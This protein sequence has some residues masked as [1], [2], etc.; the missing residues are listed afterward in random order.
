M[1]MKLTVRDIAK[2]RPGDRPYNVEDL[3]TRGLVLRVEP[4]GIMT[5][6]VRYR[7]QG[8]QS[9]KKLGRVDTMPPEEARRRAAKVRGQA[10]DGIDPIAAERAAKSSTLGAF[11]ENEYGPRVLTFKKSGVATQAR[12]KDCFDFLWSRPL[13]DPTL[14]GAVS[15]WRSKRLKEGKKPATVNRDISALKHILSWAVAEKFL[16]THPLAEVK[17]IKLDKARIVRYLQAH[18]EAAL[19]KAL[20]DREERLRA[21]RD[22][23]NAWRAERKYTLLPSLRNL[24]YVDRLKPVVLLS[25]HTGMRR[26]EV[27]NLTWDDAD[28][29]WGRVTV[30]GETSKSGN[31][32]FIP[33]NATLRGVLEA[34][35]R[36]TGGT[37][38]VFPGAN[39]GRLDNCNSSFEAVLKAAK[40]EKFRWHDMRHHFASKLVQGGVDL[41]V[42]KD[43]LGHSSIVMTERYAHLAPGA[44]ASAVALLDKVAKPDNVVDFNAGKEAHNG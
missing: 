14:A 22:S 21:D 31:T 43:L 8:R 20:D 41:Y 3:E 6:F 28:L 18:E 10:Q 15:V 39:G 37:G 7:V 27:F 5:Y 33:M 11:I 38:Y 23:A 40:I 44:G 24:A 34:W 16:H 29:E 25:L 13:G 36:Q 4:S 30:R 12:L 19:L 35:R 32:R 26:G 17:P 9:Q 42:V 1:K 2:L